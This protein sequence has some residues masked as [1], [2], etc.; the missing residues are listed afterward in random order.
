LED[1]ENRDGVQR[2]RSLMF[3]FTSGIGAETEELT[4]Q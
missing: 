4:K 2:L 1:E 3:Q